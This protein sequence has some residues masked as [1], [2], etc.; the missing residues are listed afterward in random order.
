MLNNCQQYFLS[1]HWLMLQPRMAREAAHSYPSRA[2]RSPRSSARRAASSSS[3]C[4]ERSSGFILKK[5]FIHDQ[6]LTALK[7]RMF[8]WMVNRASLGRGDRGWS[9]GSQLPLHSDSPDAPE[10]LPWAGHCTKHFSV[11]SIALTFP[12]A[13]QIGPNPLLYRRGWG[14]GPGHAGL[15]PG[16]ELT[17]PEWP[18]GPCKGPEDRTPGVVKPLT[19]I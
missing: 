11:W 12:T 2:P 6:F 8:H 7:A 5:S 10:H 1:F 9:A 14:R 4:A 13:S 3:A 16:L 19:V 18:G 17:N 15:P